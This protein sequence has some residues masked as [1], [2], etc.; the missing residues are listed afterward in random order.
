MASTDAMQRTPCIQKCK[1]R[2]DEIWQCVDI[3]N[4]QLNKTK[5][6]EKQT[7]QN[8]QTNEN[9]QTNKQSGI[10]VLYSNMLL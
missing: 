6:N 7:K 1:E 2:K 3:R 4:A 8:N 10:C 5:P 9:K